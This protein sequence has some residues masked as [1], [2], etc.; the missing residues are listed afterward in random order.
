MDDALEARKSA[1]RP[2]VPQHLK[3]AR[4][5]VTTGQ[6][7]WWRVVFRVCTSLCLFGV[8]IHDLLRMSEGFLSE[9]LSR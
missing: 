8:K 7:P 6:G 4:G 2:S 3:A 1:V 9:C 5:H